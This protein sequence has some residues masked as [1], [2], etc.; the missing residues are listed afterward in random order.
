MSLHVSQPPSTTS[1]P[2][3]RRERKKLE[4]RNRI[5]DAARELFTS[6]GFHNTTV[7]EIAAAAD[8]SPATVFNHFHSKQAVLDVMTG[9]V[10]DYLHAL[11]L[12]HLQAEGSSSERLRGFIASAA[13][14]IAASRGIARDVLLE[15]MRTDATP[16]GPHPY[17]QRLQEPFVDLVAEGQRNG[18]MRDDHTAAFLAQMTVGMLNSAITSWL[19]DPEYPVEQGLLDA[20][21]FAL[22]TLLIVPDEPERP[23][24]D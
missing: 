14:S 10:V 21:E 6:K 9:E 18:E 1:A 16:D 13:E 20:T 17:L 24:S 15:F 12:Q 8:V 7:D 11:T 4:V 22:S 2:L 5:H 19:A 23:E 3:G